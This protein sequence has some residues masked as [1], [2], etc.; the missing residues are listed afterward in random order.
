MSARLVLLCPGQGGQHAAMFELARQHPAGAALLAR[1]A[2]LLPAAGQDAEPDIGWHANRHAQ[3]LVVA[4][5]LSM[6]AALADAAPPPSLVAGYSIGE[7]AAWSVAGALDPVDAVSLAAQRALLMDQCVTGE[8]E[9]LA[10]AARQAALT[11]LP[12]TGKTDPPATAP[13]HPRA[14]LPNRHLAGGSDRIGTAVRQAAW[15]DRCL[16]DGFEPAG[17]RPGARRYGQAMLA[18]TGLPAARAAAMA[19]PHGG[20][21]AIRNGADSGVIGLP[22]GQADALRAQLAAQGGKVTPLPV[23]VASHTPYMA[24]AVQPF[25]EA[26]AAAP[27][28]DASYPVLSGTSAERL[29]RR[30]QALSHLPRQLAHTIDWDGCMDACGEAGITV[31]LELGPGNALA[32]M[33]QARHPRM[34]CRSVADFRSVEGILRWLERYC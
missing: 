4:A 24:G 17:G 13:V 19:A 26:L 10:T 1:L 30:T 16:A 6:W 21:L 23:A 25:Q 33:M 29:L 27:L 32:R 12:M 34:A 31:A 8:S 7:L 5:T 14:A 11:S 22:A 9:P 2:P 20:W 15:T 28:R 18:F 3:P